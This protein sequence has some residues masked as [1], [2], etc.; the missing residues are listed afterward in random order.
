MGVNLTD[1][2][3]NQGKVNLFTETDPC[4]FK[5]NKQ[6]KACDASCQKNR[7]FPCLALGVFEIHEFGTPRLQI[8]A[9]EHF[10]Q[11]S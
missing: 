3:L 7:V 4:F 9:A 6:L 5:P 2:I 8:A 1:L 10:K 11:S